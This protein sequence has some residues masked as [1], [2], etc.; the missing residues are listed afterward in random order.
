MPML[1]RMTKP[2]IVDLLFTGTG[3]VPTALL[4]VGQPGLAMMMF[5]PLLITACLSAVWLDCPL[6]D[7]TARAGRTRSQSL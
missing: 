3:V 7:D 5:C 4:L 1:E 6:H 2:E